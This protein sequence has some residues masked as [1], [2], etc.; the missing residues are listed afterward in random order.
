MIPYLIIDK[1][2]IGLIVQEKIN[3]LPEMI[4]LKLVESEL[5]STKLEY[6]ELFIEYENLVEKINK[7][8]EIN[9][10]LYYVFTVY[11]KFND[12]CSV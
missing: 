6:E 8:K 5:K 12:N 10:K 2:Q 7:S 3:S 11:Y 9:S 4:S 1:I